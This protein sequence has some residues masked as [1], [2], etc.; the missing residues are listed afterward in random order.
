MKIIIALLLTAST[1]LA[2]GWDE[3]VNSYCG[4]TPDIHTYAI[5]ETSEGMIISKW[6]ITSTNRPTIQQLVDQD[7]VIAAR[8]AAEQAAKAAKLAGR[9][10]YENGYFTLV[11]SVLTLANDPRKDITPIPKLSFDEL[12]AILDVLYEDNNTNKKA[13]KLAMK[14]LSVNSA[15]IRYDIQW[16][17][18]A[19]WHSDI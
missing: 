12:D 7:V 2:A 3:R 6:N 14:L 15:L 11:K 10:Q 17:E 16:W 4:S 9:K 1:L 13:T 5:S 19:S 18:G 8:E